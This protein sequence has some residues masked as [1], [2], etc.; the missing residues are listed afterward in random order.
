MENQLKL[1]HEK[2]NKKDNKIHVLWDRQR[3]VDVTRLSIYSMLRM[4]NET[5]LLFHVDFSRLNFRM[6][7]S[8]LLTYWCRDL[9][10]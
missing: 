7:S 9:F 5:F 10:I 3:W 8:M 6:I 2:A 1:G 4:R